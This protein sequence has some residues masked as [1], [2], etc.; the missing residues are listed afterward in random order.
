MIFF[1]EERDCFLKIIFKI[2]TK[3][4][5]NGQS[6]FN[7]PRMERSENC[8]KDAINIRS[9]EIMRKS[10]SLSQLQAQ[11]SILIFQKD[12]AAAPSISVNTRE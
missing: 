12:F 9:D 7:R 10:Y 2:L 11:S 5:M 4:Y 8:Y 6:S 3:A 1:F